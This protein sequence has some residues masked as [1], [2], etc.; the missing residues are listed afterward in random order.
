MESGSD[1]TEKQHHQSFTHNGVE[2]SL[3]DGIFFHQAGHME[4]SVGKILE[5]YE[6]EDKERMV[7]V[8]WLARPEQVR[9]HLND[10][11]PSGMNYMWHTVE[12]C[13]NPLIDVW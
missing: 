11:N 8:M 3:Y 6:T 1:Q 2:Y 9:E 10:L 13:F 4:T 12:A 5:L 7:K